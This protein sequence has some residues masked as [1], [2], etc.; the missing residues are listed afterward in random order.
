ME[1]SF[2]VRVDKVFGALGNDTAPSA[3][4]SP[5]LWSLTDEEIERREW[6][7]NKDITREGKDLESDLNEL[8]EEEDEEEDEEQEEGEEID[9]AKRRRNNNNGGGGESGVEEYLEVQSNIGRDCTLDYEDEEDEFDKVAAGSEETDDRIYLKNVKCADYELEEVSGYGELPSSFQVT[10]KD[11]RANH[12]AAKIRLREDA[13]ATGE[14]DGL[15]LSDSSMATN[16]DTENIK[17]GELDIDNPKPILK[18][19]DISVDTKSQKRVR[20]M[21]GPESSTHED[22]QPASDLASESHAISDNSVSEQASD[23]SK[24]ASDPSKYSAGVPDY[25][26]NPEKYTCYTFDSLDNM[27]EESNRKAHA[28]FFHDLRKRNS[29]TLM[30]EMPVELPKSIVFTPKKK[31]ENDSTAKSDSELKTRE[32]LENKRWSVDITAENTQESEISAMEEDEPVHVVDEGPRSSQKPGRQYR[33]KTNGN[34][35][36]NLD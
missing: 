2:R 16:L 18:K 26:I 11:P 32:N 6:N 1:D 8:S 30:E 9:G 3:G 12:S 7:R 22:Q 14:L 25:L 36:D 19:R 29:D 33:T 20:F 15:Q 10:A 28:D 5:A 4:V 27:D 21:A 17:K 24:Q 35:D 23:P 13:E 31:A 34:A